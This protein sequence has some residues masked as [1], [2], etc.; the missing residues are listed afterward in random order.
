MIRIGGEM[1]TEALT[2]E[3]IN[4]HSCI[5]LSIDRHSAFYHQTLRTSL[6]FTF[7][8]N[9]STLCTFYKIKLSCYFKEVRNSQVAKLSYE[10]EL[11]KMMSHFELLT[12]KFL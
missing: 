1:T 10:T 4:S 8:K 6:I 7:D 11:R 9:H 5:S 3:N 12:Q 2:E